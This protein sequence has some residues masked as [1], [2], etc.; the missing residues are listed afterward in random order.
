MYNKVY[1]CS[2][3]A[4]SITLSTKVTFQIN[5][6]FISCNIM[7]RHYTHSYNYSGKVVFITCNPVPQMFN[8]YDINI[9]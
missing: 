9:V 2:A 4:M 5:N 6:T 3:I 8:F 1:K 7:L